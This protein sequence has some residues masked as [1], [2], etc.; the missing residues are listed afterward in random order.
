M[1]GR[2][3][4]QNTHLSNIKAHKYLSQ[5]PLSVQHKSTMGNTNHIIS[6]IATR[7]TRR[8][9]ETHNAFFHQLTVCH[10]SYP[11][12]HTGHYYIWSGYRNR[13]LFVFPGRRLITDCPLLSPWFT[14]STS[15][16]KSILPNHSNNT[17]VHNS[18]F[19]V[20]ANH[21]ITQ[22]TSY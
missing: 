8:D 12:C 9:I 13:G 20:H 7:S 19:S 14:M 6:H 18:C 1:T 17:R 11:K 16:H 4:R 22:V 15:E 5:T 3:R 2:C 10:S 21:V